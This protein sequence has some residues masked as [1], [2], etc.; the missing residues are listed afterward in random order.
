MVDQ[1]GPFVV[2]MLAQEAAHLGFV[3]KLAENGRLPVGLPLK[4]N[5]TS[6]KRVLTGIWANEPLD[7]YT[8]V[9]VS[10]LLNQS[11]ILG[12]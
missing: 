4:S 9:L 10:F 1:A 7:S 12:Y 3:S 5:G 11:Q 8:H 2:L 6:P